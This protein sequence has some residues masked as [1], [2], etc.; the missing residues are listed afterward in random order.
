MEW[1]R[2]GANEG[3]YFR[4]YSEI[5]ERSGKSWLSSSCFWFYVITYQQRKECCNSCLMQLINKNSIFGQFVLHLQWWVSG[6]LW[7]QLYF[8]STNIVLFKLS[9][10]SLKLQNCKLYVCL[11]WCE[12]TYKILHSLAETNWPDVQGVDI[13]Y[14]SGPQELQTRNN[15]SGQELQ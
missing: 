13:I 8:S 4:F 9:D 3:M 1:G 10:F 14:I 5:A 15:S 11:K 2:R 7:T 6:E 12:I